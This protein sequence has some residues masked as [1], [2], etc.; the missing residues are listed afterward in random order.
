MFVRKIINELS[1]NDRVLCPAEIECENRE[2]KITGFT[3]TVILCLYVEKSSHSKCSYRDLL[4]DYM[5]VYMC[6]NT[7]N[8]YFLYA[9]PYR[10]AWSSQSLF[11]WTSFGCRMW[12]ACCFSLTSSFMR[13]PTT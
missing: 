6:E 9:L 3:A 8:N 10:A 7:I 13:G 12:P 11:H 2:T 4:L 1:A 5:G